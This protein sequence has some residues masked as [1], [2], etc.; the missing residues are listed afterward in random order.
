MKKWLIGSIV[1][2]ILVF[3]WQ[4]LS[5]AVLNVHS[6]E[7]K[8][9]AAQD[10]IMSFLS[11]TLK[12]DGMYMLP[13][14]P[15]GSSMD[16][17]QELG[18]KMHGKPWATVMYKNAYDNGM[19]MPMIRGFLVDLFLVFILI[20][21]LTRN[22]T[23]KAY[24]VFAGAVA[25]GLFTFLA[26]PYTQHNWFQTPTE[27]YTGHLVDGIVGWGIVGLWLGWWLNRK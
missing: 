22:G 20:Y 21:V 25:V 19:T 10:S 4:F 11:S 18:E 2:A 9:T 3:A 6:G 24:R 16:A 17:G 15:P 1:G 26:G 8:Y 13:T 5:W 23:P 12:D 7:A 27:T 14:V